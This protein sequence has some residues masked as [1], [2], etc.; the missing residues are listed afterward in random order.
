MIN[1]IFL[2]MGDK[3]DNILETSIAAVIGIVMVCALVIPVGVD[4][5]ASLGE[6]YDQWNSL[7]YVVI[8]MVIVGLIIAVVRYFS[9]NSKR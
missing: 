3:I 2:V 5:I 9:T 6:G 1:C 8:V 7:L 4:Q